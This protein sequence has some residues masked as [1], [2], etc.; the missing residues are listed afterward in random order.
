MLCA[1]KF[2]LLVTS[3]E[4]HPSI[5]CS[6]VKT[7]EYHNAFGSRTCPLSCN[8]V[9][10]VPCHISCHMYLGHLIYLDNFACIKIWVRGLDAMKIKPGSK[11]H[12]SHLL[13]SFT[14]SWH[15]QT[16]KGVGWPWLLP[17]TKVK[18]APATS[19]SNLWILFYFLHKGLRLY[20][21]WQ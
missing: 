8:L 21:G 11:S 3:N 16:H 12:L 13:L 20:K 15:I 18:C 9:L 5:C 19:L 17:A 10:E 1:R 14:P 2:R 7:S 4:L 6:R